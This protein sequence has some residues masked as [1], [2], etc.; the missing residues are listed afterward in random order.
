MHGP[1]CRPIVTQRVALTFDMEHP[2][3]SG[4]DP[5]GPRQILDALWRSESKA[6]FFIQGRW[7]RTQP[8]LAHRVAD[9]GHL[10]GCHSHFHGPLMS[11]TDDGI[12]NDLEAATK[13]VQETTGVMPRPWFRC[14]FGS[15]HDDSRVL[16]VIAE[17]G[18]QNVHWNVEPQD[19]VE[20]RTPDEVR[21]SIVRDIEA[22][23]HDAVVLLHTW[24]VATVRAL[25]PLL[26][27]LTASG[28]ELVRVDELELQP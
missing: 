12:R 14:P 27:D 5:D 19:W 7:A 22:L 8:A 18:Y 21:S 17:C 6:T 3:R 1:G 13:A 9:E 20:G 2:S 24:P 25:P 10:V 26:E 16:K 15:G 23:E 11:F 28:H 4:H